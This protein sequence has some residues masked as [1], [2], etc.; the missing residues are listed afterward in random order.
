MTQKMKRLMGILLTLTL[1]LGLLPGVSLTAY[2]TTVYAAYVPT[3]ADDAAALAA[4]QV[5]FNSHK[6]YIIADDSTSATAGTVT[7]LAADT[8]FNL[9]AFDDSSSLSNSYNG[10]TV[11][12]A[13]DALTTSGGSFATVADAIQPV[14]LTTNK[15]NSTEVFETTSKAKLYLLSR[16]EADALPA[17]VRK[18]DFTGGNTSFN[19]WWL[20]SPGLTMDVAALVQGEY[21]YV[22]GSGIYVGQEFGVRPA[23][24]LNLSCVC[25]FLQIKIFSDDSDSSCRLRC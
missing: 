20:R 25:C 21:G 19:E 1:L 10:S 13:L 22:H 9:S 12:R 3:A 24:N 8:S 23:L 11:K 17:N 18:I 4:K 15:Y 14:D 6:W 7:L 5:N 2:A 16:E